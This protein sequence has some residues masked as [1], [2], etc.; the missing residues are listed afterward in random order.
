MVT[1]E[2]SCTEMPPAIEAEMVVTLEQGGIIQRRGI[3]LPHLDQGAA[4]P[5]GGDD[6]IDFNFTA[7]VSAGIYTAAQTI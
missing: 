2:L 4:V 5:E 1:G 3:L 6:R 7:M